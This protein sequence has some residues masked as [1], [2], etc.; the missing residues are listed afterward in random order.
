MSALAPARFVLC[1]VLAFLGTW[2]LWSA[3]LVATDPYGTFRQ[4]GL[5]HLNWP[6]RV[7]TRVGAAERVVDPRCDVVVFGTSKV[8]FAFG[9]APKTLTGD[10]ICNGAFGGATM[11]EVEAGVDLLLREGH[12]RRAVLFL[13]LAMFHDDRTTYEDFRVSRMAAHRTRL[14]HLAWSATSWEAFVE[15]AKGF[16]LHGGP[17]PRERRGFRPFVGSHAIPRTFLRKPEYYLGLRRTDEQMASLERTLRQLRA[18]ELDVLVVIAPSHAIDIENL[19]TAGLWSM[20][21]RWKTEVAELLASFD[22]PIPGW[23]F[24]RYHRP[25]TAPLPFFHDEPIHPWWVDPIHPSELMGRMMMK[26][27]AQDLAGEPGDWETDFGAPLTPES[28]R[29]DAHAR[30][31]QRDAWLSRYPEQVDQYREVLGRLIAEHPHLPDGWA[32]TAAWFDDDLPSLSPVSPTREGPGAS[33]DF[34]E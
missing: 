32:E 14:S 21:A 29:A 13:D 22:P 17:I 30:H 7:W 11:R 34:D 4:L 31:A 23:D 18:S 2:V 26:K 19:R 27:I 10:T 16:G 6:M 25:A 28:A 24:H 12:A 1:F 9:A 20:H 3:P 15:V 5:P 33:E 8:V